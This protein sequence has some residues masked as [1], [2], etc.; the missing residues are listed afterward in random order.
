MFPARQV[1]DAL[2][3]SRLCLSR[4]HRGHDF[5]G[6]RVRAEI[7]RKNMETMPKV[8]VAGVHV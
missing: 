2:R 7:M 6:G 5:C 8:D 4:R 3:V 1:S